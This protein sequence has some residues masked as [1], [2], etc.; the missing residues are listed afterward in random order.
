M[1]CQFKIGDYVTYDDGYDK[2]LECQ[3]MFIDETDPKKPYWLVFISSDDN[4]EPDWP[5]VDT[6]D[7]EDYAHISSD[8]SWLLKLKEQHKG[9]FCGWAAPRDLTLTPRLFTLDY[10]IN[11]LYHEIK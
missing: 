7:D 11:I 4:T 3:I 2:Q 1:K 10:I 9:K 5:A 8:N 6:I